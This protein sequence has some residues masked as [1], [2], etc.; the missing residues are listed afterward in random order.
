MLKKFETNLTTNETKTRVLKI[1]IA[2]VVLVFLIA[3]SALV[4]NNVIA[5]PVSPRELEIRGW[6]NDMGT[7]G[8]TAKRQEAQAQL[9]KAGEEAVPTLMT[10][11]RS[12]NVNVRSN[13]A[14]V[15]GYIASPTATQALNDAVSTDPSQT[16]RANAAWALGEIKNASALPTL[17]RVSVLDTSEQVRS[18]AND[19]LQ[20]IQNALIQRAGRSVSDLNVIATVP[21]QPNSVY[22]ASGRDLLISHDNGVQW[23]TLKQTLPSAASS[24]T[25]NPVNPNIIFAGM[26]SLGMVLST[27]GG[28][29]WQSLTRNF[30]NQAIGDS[31]VTA[32]TVDPSNPMRVV[33]AHGIRVGGTD[34]EF[35]PLGILFSNDGGKTWGNVT[36]LQQ[37]QEVTRL[38]IQNGKVYALTTDK[39]LI[40]PLAD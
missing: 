32:I 25:V 22:L 26:Y 27:D 4:L 12:N 36:D 21:N 24:L 35:Y 28:H 40:T 10:A 16:V 18:N 39:V 33:M 17:E 15:L 11:L 23:D 6:V 2:A 9:E 31:T 5:T 38:E 37:G 20:N 30:S 19:S 29:T 34:T 14:D 8:L 13:A 1:G 3:A 7:S